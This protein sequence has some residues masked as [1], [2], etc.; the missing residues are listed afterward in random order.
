MRGRYAD[1][2]Q[3]EFAARHARARDRMAAFGMD[4]L[5]ITERLNYTYFSGHRSEQNIVDK[6]RPYVFVLPLEGEPCLITMPFEMEQVEATTWIEDVRPGGLSDRAQVI[7]AVLKDMGL[8]KARIGAEL[9][10]EQ[11]MGVSYLEFGTIRA[12]LPDAVFFDAAPLILR[13]RAVKSPQ[14]QAY[15][16]RAGRIVAESMAEVFGNIRAGATEIEIAT[17]LRRL[18]ASK[19]AERQTFNWVVSSADGMIAHPTRR[20]IAAGDVLVLDSGVEFHGYGSD[21]SRTAFVGEPTNRAADCYAWQTDLTRRTAGLLRAGARTA[22]V[23]Q[24]CRA[25]CAERGLVPAIAGRIGHGVGLESTEYPSLAPSQDVEIEAGMVFA[26]NP[27][28]FWEGLGWM[29]N[30]DNWVVTPDGGPDL[31][32]GPIAPERLFIIDA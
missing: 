26:C 10:A 8:E 25:M 17:E 13:L 23:V 19:G 1:F 12:R 21:V 31:L 2:T 20:A 11:S 28:F 29:N 32:S 22:D 27:N 3:E 14:E 18:M 15:I 9:G 6:L 7:A 5:L 24:G 16:G 30:E 4:A